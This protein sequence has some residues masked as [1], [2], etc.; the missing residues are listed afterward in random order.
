MAG[1]SDARARILLCSRPIYEGNEISCLQ[2]E[3]L[4]TASTKAVHALSRDGVAQNIEADRAAQLS[5]EYFDLQAADL[6]ALVDR[7]RA[8]ECSG[9]RIAW[10]RHETSVRVVR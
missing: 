6:V 2:I 4:N 3:V 1:P 7:P 5:V 8:Q 10:P 9:A